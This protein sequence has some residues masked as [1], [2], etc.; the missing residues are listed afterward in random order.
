MTAKGK[1]VSG[2]KM[3]EFEKEISQSEKEMEE[4]RS[5]IK[6]MQAEFENYRKALDKEKTQFE[7][8]ANERLVRELLAIVDD[9]ERL[10]CGLKDPHE[11]AGAG[12]VLKNLF[13]ALEKHGLRRIEVKPGMK[14]D[15][16]FHEALLCERSANFREGEIVEELQPGY[17]LNSKVI[18]HTKVKVS[19]G[20]S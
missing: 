12:M 14:L 5:S 16:Y 7:R 6:Y 10:C 18:R 3:K 9:M 13:A 17:A 11:K 2:E 15:P 1:T 20:D 8:L 19:K 4:L